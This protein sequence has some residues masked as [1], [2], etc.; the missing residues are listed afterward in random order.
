MHTYAIHN[1]GAISQVAEYSRRF[2]GDTCPSQVLLFSPGPGPGGAGLGGDVRRGM[3]GGG[4][5]G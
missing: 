2:M 5:G 1:V 4:G 3:G